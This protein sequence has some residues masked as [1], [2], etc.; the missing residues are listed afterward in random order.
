[1]NAGELSG[2]VASLLVFAAFYM[3]SMVPLRLVAIASNL[4][5]IVYALYGELMPVLLLH[6]ALLPLNVLRLLERRRFMADTDAAAREE[7]W[8]HLLMLHMRRGREAVSRF[9]CGR[10]GATLVTSSP[11]SGRVGDSDRN[12]ERTLPHAGPGDHGGG[13]DPGRLLQPLARRGAL[14]PHSRYGR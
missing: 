4:A 3:K 8:L 5:F 1:M 12:A 11:S 14:R 7:L 10:S 9:S 6:G 2:Y 13:A